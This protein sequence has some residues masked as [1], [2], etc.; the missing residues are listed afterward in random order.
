MSEKSSTNGAA[1]GAN[2]RRARKRTSRKTE[3]KAANFVTI[4]KPDVS[5]EQDNHVLVS[6]MTKQKM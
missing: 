6:F 4:T 1:T 3:P 2:R 5:R